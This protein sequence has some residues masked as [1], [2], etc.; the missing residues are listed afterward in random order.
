[1]VA[2]VNPT[3]HP[4]PVCKSSEVYLSHQRR[5]QRWLGWLHSGQLLFHCHSCDH[6]F[7]LRSGTG[8]ATPHDDLLPPGEVLPET[9][10]APQDQVTHFGLHCPGCGTAKNMIGIL[11]DDMWTSYRGHNKLY[12]CRRCKSMFSPPP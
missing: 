7:W 9:R 5:R 12:R 8:E 1:M 11:W 3:A 2:G 6:T 10:E 4:C